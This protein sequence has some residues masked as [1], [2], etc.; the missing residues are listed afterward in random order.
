MRLIMALCCKSNCTRMVSSVPLCTCDTIALNEVS[1]SSTVAARFCVASRRRACS[2]AVRIFKV[3]AANNPAM[4]DQNAV[5]KPSINFGT[6]PC[7]SVVSNSHRPNATPKK[8][9]KMPMLVN[10]EGAISAVRDEYRKRWKNKPSPNTTDIRISVHSENCAKN[11]FG[12]Y[13]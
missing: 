7:I 11:I 4:E 13:E 9:P 6:L 3:N 2:M 1:R 8:V 10:I 5:F 12:A